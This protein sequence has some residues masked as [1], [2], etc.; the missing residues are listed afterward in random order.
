[1][2]YF[3]RQVFSW[4]RQTDYDGIPEHGEQPDDG[5]GVG[6]NQSLFTGKGENP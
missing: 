2:I 4:C 1:M 6:G 3:L 5:Q